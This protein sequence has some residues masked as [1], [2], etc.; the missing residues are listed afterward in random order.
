MFYM[1]FVPCGGTPRD[2]RIYL[3]H[4]APLTSVHQQGLSSLTTYLSSHFTT[5]LP[6]FDKLTSFTEYNLFFA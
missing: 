5:N 1:L 2:L 3:V 6:L 4:V